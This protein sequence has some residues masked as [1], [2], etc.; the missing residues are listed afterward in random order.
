MMADMAHQMGRPSKGE[1]DAILAKPPLAFGAILKQRADELG[2]SYGEYLVA[3]A[4]QALDM[5]H[6]AP[7][8]PRDRT[9]ELD[10]PEEAATRAA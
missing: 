3:L 1:R 5:P 8:L 10:L 9:S 6:F 7:P 4:A 2:L